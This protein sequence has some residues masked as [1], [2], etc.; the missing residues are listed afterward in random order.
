MKKSIATKAMFSLSGEITKKSLT[1]KSLLAGALGLLVLSSPDSCFGSN[2]DKPSSSSNLNLDFNENSHYYYFRKDVRNEKNDV[3]VENLHP[4]VAMMLLRD[5]IEDSTKDEG[6]KYWVQFLLTRDIVDFC[7]RNIKASQNIQVPQVLQ[8]LQDLAEK[9]SKTFRNFAPNSGSS[10]GL[11]RFLAEKLGG[12]DLFNNTSGNGVNKLRSVF[13]KLILNKRIGLH[14]LLNTVSNFVKELFMGAHGG[15]DFDTV[16]GTIGDK[17]LLKEVL[18]AEVSERLK[19]EE[20]EI[21]KS[22]IS[23]Q[24]LV[25]KPGWIESK[26]E[27][28]NTTVV[29]NIDEKICLLYS[30]IEYYRKKKPDSSS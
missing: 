11:L 24:D 5:I 3:K 30:T 19:N 16:N 15:A 12:L 2:Y 22:I 8:V 27:T 21:A 9:T 7:N 4:T 25:R 13:S 6:L 29:L 28:G 23:A 26:Y 20:E 1:R 14:D 17:D 18:S 10:D